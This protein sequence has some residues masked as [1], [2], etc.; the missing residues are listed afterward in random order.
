[1]HSLVNK[2][3]ARSVDNIA[4]KRALIGSFQ[5]ARGVIFKLV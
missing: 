1:M 2:K 4:R 3:N 5:K